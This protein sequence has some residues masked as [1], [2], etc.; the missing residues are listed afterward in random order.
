[1][2]LRLCRSACV[3]ALACGVLAL[4]AAALELT[5]QEERGKQIYLTGE[6]MTGQPIMAT[7]GAAGIRVPASATP[8]AGCHGA[9]GLGRPEGGVQPSK[10]LWSQLTKPYGGTSEN[11][12]RKFPPYDGRSLSRAILVGVD[13]AGNELDKAM[14]R[15][16]IHP[17]DLA[18]L[19][20]YVKRLEHDTDPGVEPE[21]LVLGTVV[22]DVG[23]IKPVGDAVV[24]LLEAYFDDLNRNGGLYGRRL[25][26]EVRRAG[27]EQQSLDL[28][29]E[30]ANSGEVFALLAPFT[31]GLDE[32]FAEVAEESG[33][34]V[35]G[36]I[37][38]NAPADAGLRDYTF[39]LLSGLA[40]QG[41]A[42]VDYA[43]GRM[44][45]PSML[46]AVVYG[47][48]DET[49]AMAQAM[50]DQAESWGRE[51]PPLHAYQPR[52][53]D[54]GPLV[55][56]L[57]AG[58]VQYVFFA[59]GDA[60]LDRFLGAADES[61]WTPFVFAPG[62]LAGRAAVQAPARFQ[63]RLYL[64]YPS[65]PGDHSEVGQQEFQAFHAR[66]ELSRD[67]LYTQIN[68]YTSARLMV[69]ALRKAGRSVSRKGLL[70]SLESFY[71]WESGFTPPLT[72]GKNRRVGAR[73]A[74]VVTVDLS[75]KSFRSG[76]SWIEPK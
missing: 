69:E 22:P 2:S 10:L 64:A 38:Q 73:G 14:P 51:R 41:R 72:Y 12:H 18:D 30:L 44:P 27:T 9:D 25:A 24:S 3:A 19:V 23:R 68:A 61:G 1:M 71:G 75:A 8:C 45:D 43:M 33:V 49:A 40:Q 4:P 74:H 50:A 11:G 70:E 15:F 58:G 32:R 66:H 34:P 56:E 52:Q 57:R 35:V 62:Q 53:L 16:D 47:D 17:D 48:I 59:G 39:Y 46:G 13:P 76:S 21:R 42:L 54:A 36:P 60:A 55:E 6:S 67:H 29:R 26:L 63:G 5:P 20:A 37:T 28:A 31:S 7:V 65:A